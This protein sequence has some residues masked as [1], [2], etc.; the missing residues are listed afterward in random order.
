MTDASFNLKGYNF[1]YVR[2]DFSNIQP[3]NTFKL[4]IQPSGTFY[5]AEHAYKLRFRF[6]DQRVVGRE[7]LDE[8]A[9]PWGESSLLESFVQFFRE[10]SA[11]F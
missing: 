7:C 8:R 10:F 3:N 9:F 6:I 11:V 4:N 2:L 1:P 5:S